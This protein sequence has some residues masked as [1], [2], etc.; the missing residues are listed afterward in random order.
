MQINFKGNQYRL[1]NRGNA[2]FNITV[3]GIQQKELFTEEVSVRIV[4]G[5]IELSFPGVKVVWDG[6]QATEIRL[7]NT[8]QKLVCGLCGNFDGECIE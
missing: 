7:C 1:Y 3:N 5:K 6:N 8:Y 4:S 2:A